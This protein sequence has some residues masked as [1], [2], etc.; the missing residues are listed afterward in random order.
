MQSYLTYGFGPEHTF[1]KPERAVPPG[2]DVETTTPESQG[3]GGGIAA[4]DPSL[5]TLYD[6]NMRK[7]YGGYS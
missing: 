1:F 4:I 3:L 7:W 5:Y 2:L 6:Q